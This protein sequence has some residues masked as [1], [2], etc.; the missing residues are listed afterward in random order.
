MDV[1]EFKR[2][3]REDTDGQERKRAGERGMGRGGGGEE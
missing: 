1:A 2:N 3:E